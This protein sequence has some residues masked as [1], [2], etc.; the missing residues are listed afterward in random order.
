MPKHLDPDAPPKQI[1]EEVRR[2]LKADWVG[3]ISLPHLTPLGEQ[4]PRKLPPTDRNMIE[5]VVKTTQPTL[6]VTGPL[7]LPQA[8]TNARWTNSLAVPV[9]EGGHAVG[10][11]YATHSSTEP[12]IDEDLHWLTAYVSTAGPI[13]TQ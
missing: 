10:V 11:V 1:A 7:R 3:L 6:A 9:L 8:R 2:E 12:F 4:T 5:L 13:F